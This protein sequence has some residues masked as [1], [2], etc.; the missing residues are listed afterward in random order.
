MTI[1]G[2][3]FSKMHIERK[4]VIKG[5]ISI[6]NNVSVKNLEKSELSLGP[7]KQALKFSFLFTTEYKPDLGEILLEGEVI[8]LETEEK[9]DEMLKIWK[10]DK[11]LPQTMMAPVLNHVLNKCNIQALI[12]SRELN[13]PAPIPLPKVA[14]K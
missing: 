13:L 4:K 10:K 6:R 12:L 7:K 14:M 5:S 8:D 2:F 9:A 3:S 11:K 1:I